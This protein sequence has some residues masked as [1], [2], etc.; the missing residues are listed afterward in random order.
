MVGIDLIDS[1]EMPNKTDRIG[2]LIVTSVSYLWLYLNIR[3]HNAIPISYA[4]FVLGALIAVFLAFF[5][6]NFSK[7]SLHGVGIGGLIAASFFL[8][9]RHGSALVDFQIFNYSVSID[10]IFLLAIITVLSGLVLG[11]RVFLGAH[12][13]IDITGGVLAG[14]VGQL[15]ANVF[16]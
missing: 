12:R 8:M 14:I 5:I 7:I 6:N 2:P 11:S 3:T 16:Y 13:M 10:S 4:N 15:I 9:V 1:I